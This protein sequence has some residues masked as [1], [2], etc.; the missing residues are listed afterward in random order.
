MKLSSGEVWKIG[1]CNCSSI[2]CYPSRRRL[3]MSRPPIRALL[4]DLSGTLHIGSTTVQGAVDALAR[5][6]Q[7]NT[8]HASAQYPFRF[9][10]NTSKESRREL[11]ERLRGM[12]FDIRSGEPSA[13]S[14]HEMEIW[15]SLGALSGFLKKRAL[16]KPF[17]LLQDSAKREVLDDLG[18]TESGPCRCTS[19]VWLLTEYGHRW[20]K[21]I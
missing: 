16:Q 13:N 12:G 5:L 4:I 18:V 10:S 9:C 14:G 17:C 1:P 2:L 21:G 6:R 3:I 8:Q 19:L 11:E 20:T 7:H 15:T